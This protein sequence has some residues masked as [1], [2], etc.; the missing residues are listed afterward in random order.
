MTVEAP[1]LDKILMV[2]SQISMFLGDI[3]FAPCYWLSVL[4]EVSG[5]FP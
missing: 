4:P 1:F 3:T 2:L 5:R